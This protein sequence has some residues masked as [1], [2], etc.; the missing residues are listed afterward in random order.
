MAHEYARDGKEENDIRTDESNKGVAEMFG[1][2]QNPVVKALLAYYYPD[3][4]GRIKSADLVDQFKKWKAEGEIDEIPVRRN[5]GKF[6]RT[7]FPNVTWA[8][9]A[10]A[11]E[12][13]GISVKKDA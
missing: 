10:T 6:I 8:R 1:A 4:N 3:P 13:R 12:W 2:R 5:M 11:R 9:T 7:A